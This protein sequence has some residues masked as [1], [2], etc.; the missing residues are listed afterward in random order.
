MTTGIK[1]EHVDLSL[2]ELMEMYPE[3]FDFSKE[4]AATKAHRDSL[5]K[6]KVATLRE[7]LGGS[8]DSWERDGLTFVLKPAKFEHELAIM[9]IEEKYEK[10]EQ[11][12]SNHMREIAEEVSVVL[13]VRGADGL[14]SR[15]TFAQIG[16]SFVA[17]ELLAMRAVSR[18]I[19]P[20]V[21]GE[22]SENPPTP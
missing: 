17:T 6:P 7:M 5:P 4:N 19:N 10:L 9:E 21:E 13:V 22:K 3:E 18:G 20:D 16:K 12:N 1:P 2:T 11:S 15:A 14:E 8:V